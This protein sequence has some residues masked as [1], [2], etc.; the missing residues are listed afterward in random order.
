[1][2]F[3]IKHIIEG[4]TN[5][6]FVKEEVEKIA[7]QRYEICSTCPKNS[8]VIKEDRKDPEKVTEA[9]PYYSEIRLDEHCSMCACNIHA[10]V[11]SLHTDCPIGK[12]KEVASKEEAAKIAAAIDDNN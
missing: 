10:K 1:M 7:N 6:V 4:I 11:R 2:K 8:K 3:N 9:G 5:S 12:W